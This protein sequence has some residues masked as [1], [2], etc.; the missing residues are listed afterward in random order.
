[1]LKTY[2]SAFFER[3][4]LSSKWEALI[5]IEHCIGHYVSRVINN[6]MNIH[7]TSSLAVRA[8]T[9]HEEAFILDP[10]KISNPDEHDGLAL[11]D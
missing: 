1:M 11:K 4:D 5:C 8:S 9:R 6:E 3:H 10:R 2:N 7:T